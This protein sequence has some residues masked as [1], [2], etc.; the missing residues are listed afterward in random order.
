M[1][2]TAW[3]H[4]RERTGLAMEELGPQPGKESV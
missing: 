3:E 2:D 4:Y 1:I